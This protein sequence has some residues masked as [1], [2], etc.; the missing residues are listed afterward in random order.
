M[1]PFRTPA[2]TN[3]INTGNDN[4]GGRGSR[5][6]R[7]DRADRTEVRDGRSTRPAGK[8]ADHTSES[9]APFGERPAKLNH[10]GN[11][12]VSRPSRPAGSVRNGRGAGGAGRPA[13][14][15]GRGNAPAAGRN[16]SGRSDNA[17]RNP[18]SA[19]AG[20]ATRERQALD[21][22]ERNREKG[23]GT[24]GTAAASKAVAN[25]FASEQLV[26]ES[27]G[28]SFLE[29]GVPAHLIEVLHDLGA[30]SPFP[31]Q[32]AT[33]EATLSG[34]DVLGRGRTG[35]GKTIAFAIPL[36][37]RLT[38]GARRAH[39]PRGLVLLPTRE[40]A[41][42]VERT[43][44]PLARAAGLK[45]VVI[46]GGVGY[47][48]QTSALR[49]GVD[50]VI[51]C[52]GRLEDLITG[53]HVDLS[54]V[55][56]T[57]LD[58]ADHMADLG[59]LP[60]VRRLLRATDPNGQRLLFSATLDNGISVLV[61]D[62]LTDP[63]VHAVDGETSTVETLEHH[64]FAVNAA[65]R[66][67]VIRELANSGAKRLLFTRTKHGAKKW[68]EQLNKA[69]IATVDLHGNLSQN[70][71]ERNLAAFS[72]GKAKVLVATDIAARGIHVDDIELVVHL[73]PPSEHKAYLHRSGRTARAGAAGTVITIMLPEQKRD[74]ALL[75]KQAGITAT[76]NVV[77][78]G[79]EIIRTIALN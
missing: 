24:R 77:T 62:F 66:G 17:P 57:V 9:A 21:R 25:I 55:Q 74:V 32:S 41:L 64:V 51:A 73:D 18:R 33:L 26:T 20:D 4:S 49:A 52:P 6:T 10:D 67:Q 59:F 28:R 61:N 54:D 3:S 45:T 15:G 70:A 50:I 47:G 12:L 78:P 60:G 23:A 42:Q 44:A 68:A 71:R 14:S 30:D 37:T 31:I 2:R 36:V 35:S 53:N 22:Q 72:S 48:S 38:G 40:L 43:I 63:A 1:P 19:K 76:S 58:E 8:Y 5:P 16:S 29:L 79:S 39:K 11:A 27:D 7:T 65:D 69:G 56:V 13:L 34:R 46:F 75:M